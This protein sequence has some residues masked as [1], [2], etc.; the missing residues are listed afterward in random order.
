MVKRYAKFIDYRPPR[1]FT[2]DERIA[3]ARDAVDNIRIARRYY[4]GGFSP[5]DVL[6]DTR[7]V[8]L[9][10]N[11]QAYERLVRLGGG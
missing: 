5:R 10:R 7:S 6:R 3:A 4:A 1:E 8:F 2:I 11:Q 9:Y